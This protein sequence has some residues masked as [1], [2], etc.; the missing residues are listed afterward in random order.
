ME[1]YNARMKRERMEMTPE[2]YREQYMEQVTLR[3]EVGEE[4][5]C[6]VASDPIT[7]WAGGKV[8]QLYYREKT[9]PA[10]QLAPYKVH[11]DDGRKIFAPADDN[12]V[13]RLKQQDGPK[14]VLPDMP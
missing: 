14:A 11:L 1:D 9:W 8:I 10:N 3:F 5:E 13:I 7:G 4:V 6:R 12:Q 2:Y